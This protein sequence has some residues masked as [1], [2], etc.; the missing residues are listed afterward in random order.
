MLHE[1]GKQKKKI[2]RQQKGMNVFICNPCI[3]S[4]KN[5]NLNFGKTIQLAPQF[6]NQ[7]IEHKRKICFT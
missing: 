2:Y 7:I 4:W 5:K 3:N 1:I 6:F